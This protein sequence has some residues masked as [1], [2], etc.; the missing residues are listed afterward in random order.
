M[1][2]DRPHTIVSHDREQT[3]P[4]DS[5]DDAEARVKSV[6]SMLDNPDEVGIVPGSYDDYETYRDSAGPTTDDQQGDPGTPA[7]KAADPTVEPAPSTPEDTVAIDA[8]AQN[9]IEW[10]EDKN[11][12]FVYYKNGTP[13][14]SKQGFRYI[15]QQFGI[16]TESE[17]VHTYD[18]PRG[19]VVW[20]RA[21]RPNGQYAEAHGEGYITEG[22]VRDNE[23][24]RY[25]DSRAKNRAISDLTSAGALAVS[26]LTNEQ[27]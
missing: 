24:V 5:K 26:E 17:L 4:C 10:L 12:E 16:T 13:A 6:K 22:D 27:E 11:T 14:I 20:A 18:D 1:S 23:F 15:Q 21:E 25:A 9:P 7:A 8:M 19:V 2:D 3:W